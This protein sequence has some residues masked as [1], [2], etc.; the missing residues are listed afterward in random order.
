LEDLDGRIDCILRGD[1]TEIGLE[2]TVVDCT[3]EV[4]ILLRLGA[5]SV[6]DLRA[7]VPEIHV[8]DGARSELARSPGMRHQHYSPAAVVK[9]VSANARIEPTSASA[10]IGIHDRGENFKLK[11]V[12]GS[13]EEYAREVFEFFRE[14]DRSEIE[15]IY[16]E[17]MDEIGIGAALMDRLRRASEG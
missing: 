10:Y 16:C 6:D 13:V 3:V 4:P 5:V 11:K 1:L 2:S 12:C 7:V 8:A 9:L 15:M 14:C 17:I